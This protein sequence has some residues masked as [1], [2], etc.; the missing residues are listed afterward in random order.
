MLN[1][2]NRIIYPTKMLTLY[3]KK[4]TFHE[5]EKKYETYTL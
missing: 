1:M 2:P 4:E 5:M 3:A